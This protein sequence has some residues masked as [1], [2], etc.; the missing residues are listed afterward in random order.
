[1][2]DQNLGVNKNA[3]RQLRPLGF[4]K[5]GNAMNEKVR[6]WLELSEY[7]LETADAML[8]TGRYL[9]V[10]FMCHQTIEKAL[11]AYFE[12]AKGTAPP[13]THNLRFLALETGLTPTLSTDHKNLLRLLE[14]L[15]IAARYP[16][17]KA[18]LQRELT[19]ERCS[20]ILEE[21][22]EFSR[23]IMQML[24]ARLPNTQGESGT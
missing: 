18:G 20:E 12:V 14:P 3:K 4:L 8:Q 7:D 13:K 5:R 17:H 10:G 6:Y 24:C 1:M 23:W 22:K 21:T 2:P 15:N 11:K 9:Y 19:R 16:E